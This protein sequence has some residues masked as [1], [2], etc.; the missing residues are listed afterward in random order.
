MGNCS[1][2]ESTGRYNYDNGEYYIG[3]LRYSTPNGK[4]KL[5][6]KNGDIKYDGDFVKGK[7]HGLGKYYFSDYS[8]FV[9]E[10]KKKFFFMKGDYYFGQFE[11]D[12]MHGKGIIYLVD[13]RVKYDGDLVNNKFEGNGKYYFESGG[14]YVGQLKQDMQ[15]GYGKMYDKDGSLRFEGNFVNDHMH[16][17]G[18]M[19]FEDG[20]YYV[21]QFTNGEINGVGKLYSSNGT[22]L[23]E[24][25][26]VNGKKV[27]TVPKGIIFD[28]YRHILDYLFNQ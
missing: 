28:N 26:Y 14:Y 18:K 24:D 27:K 12:N 23:K 8:W 20:Q 6:Y 2:C 7:R 16:G 11:N 21:A 19:Y 17:M 13:G 3:E 9:M 1:C 10:D 15:H 5:Y 22:L 25:Y 4:G